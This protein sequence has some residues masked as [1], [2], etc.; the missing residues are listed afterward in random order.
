MPCKLGSHVA[1]QTCC[2]ALPFFV[3][4]IKSCPKN[5]LGIYVLNHPAVPKIC[6]PV[7]TLSLVLSTNQGRA[8][9]RNF[10]MSLCLHFK[11]LVLAFTSGKCPG[12]S[13]R[14][15][16]QHFLWRSRSA[17]PAKL[18]CGW[19]CQEVH[20]YLVQWLA[21]VIWKFSGWK[22]KTLQPPSEVEPAFVTSPLCWTS[23]D[24]WSRW[25]TVLALPLPLSYS[26]LVNEAGNTWP[27]LWSCL[28]GYT[29]CCT[30]THTG[31]EWA[32]RGS[33]DRPW[34]SAG[35]SV[36]HTRPANTTGLGAAWH[37]GSKDPW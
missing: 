30:P 22:G 17:N 5:T 7:M 15:T 23:T 14:E 18:C 10:W 31:V 6:V 1:M 11:K 2:S 21:V 19:H 12:W 34:L 24:R 25:I 37:T 27:R 33:G 28:H 16:L 3:S 35:R 29:C 9:G 20:V 36:V 4:R 8:K 13:E 32:L 26:E